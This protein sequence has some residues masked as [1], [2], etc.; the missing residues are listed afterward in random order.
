MVLLPLRRSRPDIVDAE[1]F[2]VVP[3][4]MLEPVVPEPIELPVVPEPVVPEPVVPE[5]IELPVVPEPVVPEPI[6]LP[7]VPEPLVP[8]LDVPPVPGVALM[9]GRCEAL[10]PPA[11]PGPVAPGVVPELVAPVLPEVPPVVELPGWAMEPAANVIAAARVNSLGN[12]LMI[13]SRTR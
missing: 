12:L 11:E 4:D 8:E 9:V 6:E 13:S 1:S 2:V 10:V 5:P 7:V 3:E